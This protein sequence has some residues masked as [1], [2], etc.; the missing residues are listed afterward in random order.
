MIILAQAYVDRLILEKFQSKLDSLEDPVSRKV[1]E[2]VY[3]LFALHQISNHHDWYLEQDYFE[4]AKTKAI[5]R[6]VERLSADVREDASILVS[7]FGIP[8]G[9]LSAPIAFGKM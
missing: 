8:D 9:L 6:H 7:S 3:Q 4:G 5:R 1:M 2:K